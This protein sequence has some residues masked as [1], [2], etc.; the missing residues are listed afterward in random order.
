[1]HVHLDRDDYIVMLQG[2][3]ML[4]LKDLRGRSPSFWRTTLVQLDTETPQA[5]IIPVGVLHGFYFPE[6][7][8]HV[9]GLSE[10]WS[11]DTDIGCRWDDPDLGLPWPCDEP[12]VIE[13][14][15]QLGSLR[16]LLECESGFAT[17]EAQACL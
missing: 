14:D 16:A 7:S 12:M 9:Y 5:A 8:V 4:G 13:R 10:Y 15:L 1:M 6:G 17:M 3:M 2:R 11:P